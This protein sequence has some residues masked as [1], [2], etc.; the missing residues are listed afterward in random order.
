MHLVESVHA[1]VL[2]GGS[3]FGLDAATGVMR[4]LEERG[5]GYPTLAAR[6]P[7][8][9]AAVLYDLEIGRSDVRPDA[10]MGYRACANAGPGRPAEGNAGAGM[11]AT[12]GHAMG[13]AQACK[14]GIGTASV[15]INAG[16]I[17]GALVA[18]NP[19]GDVIDPATGQ[20]V[21]G[22]RLPEDPRVAFG[23]RGY[24]ADSLEMLRLFVGPAVPA[25]AARENTVIGVVATN[26]RLSKEQANKVAQMAQDGLARA[27][28]PAHTLFDG[29]TLFC[30]ATGEREADPSIV[31]AFAAEVVAQAIVSACRAALPVAGLPAAG[32]ARE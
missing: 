8:V 28:R 5:I 31:G 27:V 6:V 15:D 24:F 22:T 2:A 1:V 32:G 16:V 7:I 11:G 30:L 21:A 29:D 12:V 20:I 4:Y 25:F 9:P 10:A 13:M 26:A 14:A 23:A 19:F 17:V 3:A 18:A